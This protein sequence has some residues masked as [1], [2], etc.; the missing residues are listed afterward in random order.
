MMLTLRLCT[1]IKSEL[2]PTF[3]KVIFVSIVTLTLVFCASLVGFANINLIKP[4]PFDQL[5][6]PYLFIDETANDY[7][8]TVIDTERGKLF[9]RTRVEGKFGTVIGD[10]HESP[11]GMY[12]FLNSGYKADVKQNYGKG[13]ANV[14]ELKP[15]TGRIVNKVSIPSRTDMM[16]NVNS[17][18]KFLA[19]RNVWTP[20]RGVEFS[21]IDTNSKKVENF[22]HKNDPKKSSYPWSVYLA[23]HHNIKPSVGRYM[24]FTIDASPPAALY[25][26]NPHTN[27]KTMLH[28]WKRLT[29]SPAKIGFGRKFIYA[30]VYPALDQASGE[31]QTSLEIQVLDKENGRL[32]HRLPLPSV[33]D[34]FG[35]KGSRQNVYISWVQYD[36]INE[37]LYLNLH[38]YKPFR[39]SSVISLT[40]GS[41][42]YQ[43][44]HLTTL[45]EQGFNEMQVIHGDIYLRQM[46]FKGIDRVL[47][48]DPRTKEQEWVLGDRNKKGR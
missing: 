34:L 40:N 4:V 39:A 19:V 24:Y 37:A 27:K 12:Y 44:S 23:G 2:T 17:G 30:A 3:R 33:E 5:D 46:N 1:H 28:V 47:R 45:W 14:I 13:K 42:S 36:Q 9:S 32:E 11:S 21:L 20:K 7:F 35:R 38:I 41:S 8:L 48:F 22:Y 15:S 26:F 29:Y 6:T 43:F 31:G 16:S 25:R 10:I 18:G